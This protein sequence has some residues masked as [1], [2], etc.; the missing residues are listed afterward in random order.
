[1][2]C[3]IKNTKAIRDSGRALLVEIPGHSDPI[4]I[5]QGQI[6]EDSEVWR[7]GDEGDL[8]ITEWIAEQKGL[9]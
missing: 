4:W 1:M 8:V 2:S 3:T 5:P 7:D 9:L 6:D